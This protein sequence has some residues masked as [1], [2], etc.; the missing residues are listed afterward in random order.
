MDRH[1]KVMELA[2]R[3]G[4]IWPAFEIYGGVS[5]FYDFGPLGASLKKKIED[6]WRDFFILGE[7]FFE[8][9]SPT[10]GMQD[11]FI[12]SGHVGGFVDPMVECQKCGE[13]YRA[14][15]LIQEKIKDIE[16]DG[17]SFEELEEL[18]DK[19]KIKCPA[20][21]GKFGGVWSFN[22]MFKTHIGPGSKKVGYLRPE[23][24]QAMFMAF[25]RLYRFNRK[26]LPLGIAQLGRAYR[27]EISPRQGVIRLR[28]FNQAEAEVFVHPSEK[29]HKKFDKISD[30]IIKVLPADGNEREVTA[31][32]AVEGRIVCH[33][34]L[35]YYLILTKKFL[36][37][38]GIP[39]D[40]IRFRQHKETERAHYAADCWDVEIS[41]QRFGWIEV[42]G[43]ADRTDYDL[44]AHMK[45]SGEDLTAFTPFKEPKVVEKEIIEANMGKIGPKYKGKAG[46]MVE[47]IKRMDEQDIKSFKN[48]GFLELTVGNKLLHIDEELVTIKKV[49]ETVTGEKFV[50]H[51]IEPSFGID[52]IIYS[53]LESAY[54]ERLERVVMS[55]KNSVVPIEVAVFPLVS[56]DALPSIALDIQS[57]LRKKGFLTL[58]DESDSIGR[59]YA[60]VDEIGVPYAVTVDFDTLK[61]GTVTLR[62]RDSTAQV[63]IKTDALTETLK[64]LL[65]EKMVFGDIR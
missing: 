2:L 28:E 10:V 18:I 22:L 41:T 14:D 26:K 56:K 58:Y 47:A 4:F 60:R 61:D 55:F 53:I 3:R 16:T 39:E 5:G 57:I 12:A 33:E 24:A 32:E 34:L 44:K 6:K 63:R 59:R 35:T 50:P 45:V 25:P 36:E 19:N 9:S 8:I 62:E 27:N 13:A 1:Q 38:L 29:K 64:G 51:V 54:N 37:S 52:R 17:L 43:I 11:V 48:K 21:K 30:E 65:D 46:E 23:T 20:C 7:G 42:V 31:K 49:K 40:K 15:H